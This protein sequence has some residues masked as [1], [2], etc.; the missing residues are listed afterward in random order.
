MGN[1]PCFKGTLSFSVDLDRCLKLYFS[2]SNGAY[3]LK[4][5]NNITQVMLLYERLLL[6]LQVPVQA[7]NDSLDDL[8]FL[9]IIALL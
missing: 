9:S 7:R 6:V 5:F 8:G 3:L 4:H 2:T 1:N